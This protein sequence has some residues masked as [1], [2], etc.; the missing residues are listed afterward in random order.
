MIIDSITRIDAYATLNPLFAKVAEF[1]RSHD[2]S[3]I[4]CG[5]HEIDGD[6]VYVNVFVTS[7]KA[8]NRAQMESHREMIDIHVPISGDEVQGFLSA[9][10]VS[11][12]P[13]DA[14]GDCSLHPDMP[15]TYYTVR[16]GEMAIHF[17]G[18]GHS[19]AISAVPLKKA[20]FKI[21]NI[22]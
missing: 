19:P 13:Y 4:E 9:S 6:Q 15:S 3:A 20:V 1:L 12:Q 21:K 7:P 18:E 17:P 16:V 11:A 22:K 8:Y 10:A 14:E 2:M 5:R